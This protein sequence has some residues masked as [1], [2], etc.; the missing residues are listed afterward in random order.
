MKGERNV[1]YNLP[2]DL[3]FQHVGG[4]VE[5]SSVA[6]AVC[7]SCVDNYVT[8]KTL[9][10]TLPLLQPGGV[11]AVQCNYR[12]LSNLLAFADDSCYDWD[13]VL[14]SGRS[15]IGPTMRSY[16]T[17]L[18]PFVLLS[19]RQDEPSGQE[20]PLNLIDVGESDCSSRVA[21]HLVGHHSDAG[22]L[23]IFVGGVSVMA[24]EARKMGRDVVVFG[25]DP[26]VNHCLA[27]FG[28]VEG[29]FRK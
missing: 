6:L 17:A 9:W 21:A 23:V 7:Q 24:E 18:V 25:N 3:A 10:K 19:E 2:P 13:V 27:T 14:F 22:D 12:N 5:K 28:V 15:A 26:L 20:F 16:R 11:L 29:R 4:A 8:R 1:F